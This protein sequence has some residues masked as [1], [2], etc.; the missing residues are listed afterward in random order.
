MMEN[1]RAYWRATQGWRR[2][3]VPALLSVALAVTTYALS[4]RSDFGGDDLL[5][6][7]NARN[8]GWSFSA[9]SHSFAWDQQ[10]ITEGWVPAEFRNFRLVYFR[11][12]IMA[13]LKM[14]LWLWGTWAPGFYLTN[15]LLH[16]AITYLVY[17]WGADFGLGRRERLLLVLLFG[18]YS[19]NQ[20]A[21]VQ[22]NGRTELVAALFMLASILSLGRFHA[23]QHPLPYMVA[24]IAAVL[25]LGA[26][27]NAIMLPFF[28]LLAAL[29]LYPPGPAEGRKGWR[30]RGICL[31]PFFLLVPVYLV[32]RTSLLGGFPLPPG[33]F[34]FHDP[35]SSGFLWFLLCKVVHILPA[36][37]LQVPA[38]IWPMLVERSLLL[39]GLWCLMA[40]TIMIAL[41]RL[42]RAPFRGVFGGWLLLCLAPTITMGHNPIYYFL[43][44]PVVAVLYVRLYTMLM[45]SSRPWRRR[46]ATGLVVASMT[47]GLVAA[48]G[49]ALLSQAASVPPRKIAAA[50]IDELDRDP[51]AQKVYVIDVP[52]TCSYLM[53]AVRFAAERHAT[54]SLVALT[55]STGVLGSSPSEIA[56]RDPFTFEIRPR[57]GAYLRTGVEELF[58]ARPLPTF[59]EGMIATHPDYRVEII[60]VESTCIREGDRWMLALQRWL[61]MPPAHQRG[62]LALRF[63]FEQPLNTPGCLFLQVRKNLVDTVRFK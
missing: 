11:P 2:A 24:F 34:Y 36:L 58:L 13:T 39:A 33:G 59:Q 14:D 46:M 25:A 45:A 31:L 60:E 5:L 4:L 3:G 35:R 48:N 43:C 28:H 61:G 8:T 54:K 15:I 41:H 42:T 57:Q 62:I 51:S 18:T 23:S 9:L 29:T 20:A 40:V 37:L 16:G 55:V 38:L 32:I 27:E 26:K 12:V 63:H 6:V 44:S 21:V 1:V 50:V 53:P 52:G 22:I 49:N 19:V 47:F 56:Q 30:R 10:D 17:L 7:R